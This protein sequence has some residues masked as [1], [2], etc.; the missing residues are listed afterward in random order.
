VVQQLQKL[1]DDGG[2][3]AVIED[4]E[5]RTML[6]L[7]RFRAGRESDPV[8]AAWLGRTRPLTG[9]AAIR[10]ILGLDRREAAG[11]GG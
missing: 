7:A 9:L 1:V 6:A 10:T 3:R 4:S 2:R 8:F 5:W 11:S